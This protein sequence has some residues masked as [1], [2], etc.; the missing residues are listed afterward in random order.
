MLRPARDVSLYEVCVALDDPA[1]QP[2]CLFGG[3]SCSDDHA[4]PTHE[5]WKAHQSQLIGYLKRTTIQDVADFGMRRMARG[6]GADRLIVDVQSTKARG[7]LKIVSGPPGSGKTSYCLSRVDRARAAGQDVA[8]IVSVAEPAVGERRQIL[9]LDLRSSERRPL[10]DLE[11]PVGRPVVRSG[12]WWFHCG[13]VTWA[14][15]VLRDAGPCDLL[16]VDEIGPL[17]LRYGLGLVDALPILHR[18]A[19]GEA[20]VTVRPSLAAALSERWPWAEVLRLDSRNTN[21][22]THADEIVVN[23]A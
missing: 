18:R 9:A 12:R 7:H 14:N 8:G 1:V 3:T 16:V 21:D 2:L 4:C 17:E 13:T 15:R 22:A 5:F 23:G 11:P 19:Y 20:I 6:L 10:A